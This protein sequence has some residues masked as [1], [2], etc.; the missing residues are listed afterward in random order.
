MLFDRFGLLG[1]ELLG[2]LV[3]SL[4]VLKLLLHA[5][6]LLVEFVVLLNLGL[7]GGLLV[8]YLLHGQAACGQ[9]LLKFLYGLLEPLTSPRLG[10]TTKHPRCE[11]QRQVWGPTILSL[12]SFQ[13]PLEVGYDD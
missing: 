7:G 10:A 12:W 3:E 4:E 2:T 9:S 1:Q 8:S 6:H 13:R 11:Q 5:D